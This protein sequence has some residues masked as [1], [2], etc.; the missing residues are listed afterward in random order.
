MAKKQDADPRWPAIE[1]RRVLGAS[2][3]AAASALLEKDPS[4]LDA[5][6]YGSES[7]LHFWAVENR[8]DLVRWL[9]E[10]GADPNRTSETG[11]ALAA[12]A[13]LGHVEVCRLL[14]A[15]GTDLAFQDGG[16]ETALH[17][18]A[19]TGQAA[20]IEVLLD[21]GAEANARDVCGETPWDQALPRKARGVRALLGRHGGKPGRQQGD[22]DATR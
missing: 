1:L 19:Q 7:T 11:S 17:K 15:A 2:D 12:A 14:V 22:V 20:V 13:S 16:G 3:F 6:A 9:L 5:S 8:P 10:R 4:I 21:A 18:A